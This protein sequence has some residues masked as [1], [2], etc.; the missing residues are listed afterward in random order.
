MRVYIINANWGNGGPGGIAA[1]IYNVLKE[2]GHECKFAYGRGNIPVDISSYRIGTK[3]DVYV[4]AM[5][6]RL[7][8]NA[9]FMSSKATENLINEINGFNPDVIS[10][11]NPLGYTLNVEILFKF[12]RDSEI[13]TFWTLHD[14]WPIT[15]HCIFGFCDHWNSGCG[16]CPRKREF[17][18]SIL[19]DRSKQNFIRKNALFSEFYIKN[20]HL[21]APSEWIKR[22]F[23]ETYLGS[24]P[25]TVIPNGIDLDVFRPTK[26][27]IREILGLS[28]KRIL[29]AVASVWSQRKGGDYL[30]QIV[31]KLDDSYRLVMIGKNSEKYK[32]NSNKILAF[33]KTNDRTQLAQWYT[34]A[35]VFVNPT[36]GDNFPTVNL[37][38][39]ACGTPVVTFDTGGSSES[40][41]NCGI[42]VNQG[43]TTSLY[44]AIVDCIDRKIPPESCVAQASYYNKNDRYKDYL[45]LFQNR[46]KE[47]PYNF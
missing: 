28:N 30:K 21:I 44:N 3:L 17:P 35:D 15:G 27:D 23:S 36:I 38:A 1:D 47:K 20:L 19:L 12:I 10:L 11:H 31:E 42:V 41:G 37:E 8:D 43:N 24:Y 14:C 33:D 6:T 16:K 4:H 25:T 32:N 40:V 5:S 2:N 45:K 22:V 46:L 29:L 9:G 34:A 13:P 26:S 18:K 7:F 39:L